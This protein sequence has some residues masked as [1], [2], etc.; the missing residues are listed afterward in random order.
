MFL[1]GALVVTRKATGRTI[2]RLNAFGQEF[3]GILLER[4][5]VALAVLKMQDYVKNNEYPRFLDQLSNSYCRTAATSI[6]LKQ[7]TQVTQEVY[8]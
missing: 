8:C 6:L 2:G 7:G 5:P 1:S 4:F 3:D